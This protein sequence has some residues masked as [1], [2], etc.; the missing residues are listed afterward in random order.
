[1]ILTLTVNPAIDRI[2]TADRLVFE[3]RAYILS[4]GESAGGRGI[5][6]SAVLHSFGAPTFA[7]L[8]SGGNS[9]PRFEADL[10]IL[11]FPYE[12]VPIEAP[13]R[14]N[15]ILMDRQ[16]LTIKLNEP[17]PAITEGE[18]ARL[19]SA[20]ARHLSNASWLMLVGS[21]P[22]GV[23]AGFYRSLIRQAH[24]AGVKTLLDTDGE[25]LQD[26]ILEG[27]TAVTPNR[28]EA[29]ALLNKSLITRQ[30]YRAA[31][32]RVLEM[33][34]Q[35]V[36]ISLG[37]RGAIGARGDQ[38]VEAV[39]PRVDAVSPIG[40]GDALNAAYAWAMA[41]NDDF[42]DAVRWGVAAGS[43]SAKLPGMQF[44]NLQQTRELYEQIRV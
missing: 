29:S 12:I 27:P 38:F 35:S 39:P 18:L 14:S 40:A 7:I 10:S 20:V 1:M 19:E 5:N 31:A 13:V 28:Q 41:R 36:V 32:A 34:A 8:P 11:G 23:P 25:I 17:G 16:G 22:P 30:H 15:L 3:D 33:G 24:A 21:L 44:A 26:A 9:G 43:A 6:A 42:A 4:R 2:I 37:S